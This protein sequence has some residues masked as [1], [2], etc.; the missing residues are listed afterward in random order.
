[1]ISKSL[2][3]GSGDAVLWASSIVSFTTPVVWEKVQRSELVIKLAV[4]EFEEY[5][6]I[7]PN[8]V[9]VKRFQ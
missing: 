2:I 4:A 5:V 7:H 6:L 9:L 3:F 1:M 8:Q